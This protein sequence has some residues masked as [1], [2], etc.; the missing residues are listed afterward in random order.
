MPN[1]ENLITLN[2]EKHKLAN[3]VTLLLEPIKNFASVSVGFFLQR[4]SRDEENRQSG[5]FHFCEHMLFKGNDRHNKDEIAQLFDEMGGYVNAYTT[6]EAVVLYNRLP[7]YYLKSNLEAMHSMLHNSLF[8][9]EEVELE[10]DVILNEIKSTFEDPP[11]KLQEDFFS[12]VFLEQPL[13][14]PIIGTSEIIS[15]TSQENLFNFYK[16]NFSADDMTVSIAGNFDRDQIL[17]YME[18]LDFRRSGKQQKLA[19]RQKGGS[20]NFTTLPSEQLHLMAGTS[21]FELTDEEYFKLSLLNII[22][23]ESMSSRL[24][25]K[26]REELGLCYTIYSYI[27]RYRNEHLFAIYTS[28][29]PK[30]SDRVIEEISAV[31]RELL[32]KGIS[33]SELDNTINHKIGNIILSSDV[34]YKRMSVNAHFENKFQGKFNSNDVIRITKETTVE[35]INELLQRVLIKDNFVTQALYKEEKEIAKWNF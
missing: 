22:V 32:E 3:G 10:R 5:Y 4:G 34:L 20:Y 12:N 21:L 27:Q 28:V 35:E 18:S 19:A 15:S 11:D 31:F 17:S 16:S 29:M 8:S 23:G 33:Q 2:L 13:G 9:K 6:H 25:M 14:R 30:N 7:A 26:I 1:N 24:F